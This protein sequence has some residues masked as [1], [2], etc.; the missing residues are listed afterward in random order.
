M[1]PAMPAADRSDAMLRKAV[2]GQ[3]GPLL[4]AS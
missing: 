2:G 4:C 1:S 3:Y